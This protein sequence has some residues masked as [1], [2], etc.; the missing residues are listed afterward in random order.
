[1]LRDR[2]PE[3]LAL[4]PSVGEKPV[5]IPVSTIAQDGHHI[6]TLGELLS[7]LFGG[8]NVERGASAQVEALLI[9][10]AVYH[11]NGLFV[12]DGERPVEQIDVGLQVVGDTALSNAL[13]DTAST[14]LDQVAAALDV[15]VENTAW[16]IGKET[17]H[18][19]IAGGL[20][21]PCDTSKSA[22]CSGS[23]CERIDL[24]ISLS[25]DLGS[26]G[27]N[28]GLAVGGVVELVRPYGIFQRLGM[29]ARLVVVILRV[30]KCNSGHRIDLGT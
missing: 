27:L 11:L 22:S 23:T 1:M 28:V 26:S 12:A 13:R 18:A 17:L 24:S 7:D 16:R 21:V 6:A 8:D 29:S 10:A 20:E 15:A 9:K 4:K 19:A 30:V 14:S 3:A 5:S 2:A 25:P